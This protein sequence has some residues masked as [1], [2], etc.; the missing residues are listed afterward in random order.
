[1]PRDGERKYMKLAFYYFGKHISRDINILWKVYKKNSSNKSHLTNQRDIDTFDQKN[2]FKMCYGA[3]NTHCVIVVGRWR[4]WI[5]TQNV[6]INY[7]TVVC[8]F[9]SCNMLLFTIFC[10]QLLVS[11]K[12]WKNT[13]SG[14]KFFFSFWETFIFVDT[15]VLGKSGKFGINQ[16]E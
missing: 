9:F 1:M 5:S 3:W 4:M 12:S 13:F 14:G 10:Y 6:V 2:C 16:Y 11:S 7:N 15:K 8:C